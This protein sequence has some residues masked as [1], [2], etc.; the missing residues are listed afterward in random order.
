MEEI[1]WLGHSSFKIKGRGRIIYIDP[2]LLH[3]HEPADFIFITHP[4]PRHFSMDDIKTV[5]REKTNIYAPAGCIE[6]LEPL[7]GWTIEVTPGTVYQAG[8]FRVTAVPA[9]NTR[10]DRHPAG[11]LW[12]GYIIEFGD[13]KVYHAGDTGLIPEMKDIPHMDYALL[14]VS[15]GSV[16]NAE[17]AAEAAKILKPVIA[18]PMHYSSE[19]DAAAFRRLYGGT[20]RIIKATC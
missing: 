16:M 18:V 14:P 6:Q 3:E 7:P 11:A 19:E 20:T 15:G 2:Y 1:K 4:H 9:Y 17:E 8:A 10:D 13:M 12:S 5:A